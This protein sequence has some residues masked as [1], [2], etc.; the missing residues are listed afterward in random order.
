VLRI[1]RETGGRR[2]EITALNGL[3]SALQALGHFEESRRVYEQGIAGAIELGQG[4]GAINAIKFG[5]GDVMVWQGDLEG[6]ARTYSAALSTAQEI[7]DREGT[8]IGFFSLAQVHWLQGKFAEA[9]DS[10]AQAEQIY[11]QLRE[12][13]PLACAQLLQADSDALRGVHRAPP[14]GCAT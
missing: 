4:Q 6:G 2:E 7:G 11:R 8:A 1:G 3:A 9:R 13:E 10:A 5:L 12:A 14:A